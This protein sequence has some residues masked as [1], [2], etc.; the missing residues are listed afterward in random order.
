MRGDA[1]YV[2][3]AVARQYEKTFPKA[4]YMRIAKAG[5]YLWLDQPDIFKSAIESFLA[6]D[7]AIDKSRTERI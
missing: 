1:D 4:K 5:H 7:S 3:E 6:T 2:P